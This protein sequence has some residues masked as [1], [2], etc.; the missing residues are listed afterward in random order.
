MSQA[1][2]YSQ[3]REDCKFQASLGYIA[4]PKKEKK[5]KIRMFHKNKSRFPGALEKSE[6]PEISCSYRMKSLGTYN[7]R[8]NSG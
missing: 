2:W 5:K 3:R 4:R 6:Y 7:S 1:W 8:G